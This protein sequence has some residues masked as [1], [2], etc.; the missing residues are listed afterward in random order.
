[1]AQSKLYQQEIL[2]NVAKSDADDLV[3]FI[4]G[5]RIDI[6]KADKYPQMDTPEHRR[7]IAEATKLANENYFLLA[8]QISY[9]QNLYEKNKQEKFSIEEWNRE[10]A[11]RE[12]EP[13]TLP[14]E[15]PFIINDSAKARDE[16]QA[17]LLIT[18]YVM[19]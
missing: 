4:E 12:A 7:R 9:L 11:A 3:A 6:W 8:E 14:K 1:M 10:K 15:A 18:N 17:A 19:K 5:I 16:F 13:I 2:I